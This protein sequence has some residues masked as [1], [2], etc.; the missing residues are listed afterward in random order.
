MAKVMDSIM[1]KQSLFAGVGAAHLPNTYGVINLLREL[2]Y[3]V[4]PVDKTKTEF[5]RN[6]KDQIEATFIKNEF[7]SKESFDGRYSVKMPGEL[8]E[9][10]ESNN[11]M[12]AAYPD[13]ANGAT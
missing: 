13:M 3:V 11:A 7:T 5:N 4:T 10:P 12:L 2:G 8:Y 1:Q 9:F 6:F